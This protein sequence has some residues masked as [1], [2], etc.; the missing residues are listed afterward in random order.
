MSTPRV[1]VSLC[2]LA[3]AALLNAQTP[4][5]AYVLTQSVGTTGGTSTTYRSGSMVLV[6]FKQPAQGG[7]PASR[8]LSI[9]DLTAGTNTTWDPDAS[10]IQCSVGRFSG[11]WGDP[12]AMIDEVNKDIASGDIKPAG[13]ETINGIA[14]QLY[15]G[16]SQ[17]AAIKVW[18]DK[19]DALVIRA[20][21][22][23]PGTAP[24][25]LV[26]IT[27]VSLAPP[28]ASRF[29]LPAACAGVK[30]PPTLAEL[31]ADETSDDPANY[32]NNAGPGS[33]NGCS[34]VLEVVSAKTMTPIS[35]I[36]VVIDTAVFPDNAPPAYTMG[37]ADDG[38]TTYSGGHVLEIT[39]RVH[40]GVVRLGLPPDHFM[41][42]VNVPL[43][44]HGG[45]IGL[46]YRQ[47][48]A[49]TTVLLDV[50]KDYGKDDQSQ[51]FLWVK[52]GKYTA[53]PAQR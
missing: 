8:S 42:G 38:M 4:P 3:S 10:P 20:T 36:Q 29:V 33:K 17:G 13:T 21:A 40:N 7:T 52:S 53:V 37:V 11:D 43:P 44:H 45:G 25:T 27:R 47:C 30:P 48:F 49:P 26:D 41:L 24:M 34:V 19:K 46:V 51:D 35:H 1:F 5:T 15:A 18:L 6:D 28:P 32:V 9:Y 50:V 39:N 22:T 14:T 16:N 2:L 12:F 31:I 23:A